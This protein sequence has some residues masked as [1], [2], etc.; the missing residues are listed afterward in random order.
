MCCYVVQARQ[1]VFGIREVTRCL[2]TKSLVAVVVSPNVN[3]KGLQLQTAV[4]SHLSQL[5][6]AAATLT[7]VAF[8]VS[9]VTKIMD[10]PQ[11]AIF[12]LIIE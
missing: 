4:T 6:C 12:K 11:N 10:T 3:A 7:I 2:N 9:L 1:I 5:I 8:S